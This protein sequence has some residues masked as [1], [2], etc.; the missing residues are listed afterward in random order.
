VKR[1]VA[2]LSALLTLLLIG[3]LFYVSDQIERQSTL[4]EARPA[5][6]IIVLGAAQY[7]GRP[8]P[9]VSPTTGV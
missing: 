9:V 8:S 5:D 6:V 4:D 3:Y 7:R 1:A 2:A